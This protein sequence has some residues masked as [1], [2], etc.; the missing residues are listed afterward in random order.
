MKRRHAG[1]SYVEVLVAALLIAALLVPALDAMQG[2]IQGGAIHAEA[3]QNHYRLVAKMEQALA[4]PFA[5]LL[6]QADLVAG[7]TVP[8]PPP[9]SDPAGSAHRRLVFLARYDGD[10]AD[11][12]NDP[13]TGVDA[14]LLWLRV[15]LEDRPRALETVIVD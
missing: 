9:Y 3:A 14:G 6:A 7:P 10:N 2:G 5:E 12:D 4:V 8:V 15:A 1:F 13:F 11:A